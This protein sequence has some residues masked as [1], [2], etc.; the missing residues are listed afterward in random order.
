MYNQDA[1]RAHLP[2][3]MQYGSRR[4]KG[5]ASLI[6]KDGIHFTKSKLYRCACPCLYQSGESWVSE[7][8]GISEGAGLDDALCLELLRW[9]RLLLLDRN[10]QSTN[11]MLLQ[12]L[13]RKWLR[14]S[15][16]TIS[17]EDWRHAAYDSQCYASLQSPISR[18]RL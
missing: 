12:H 15:L 4:D 5:K 9:T 16:D 8:R 13:S 6:V 18:S 7:R 2:L 10:H 11:S 14:W 17:H 1:H 3:Y